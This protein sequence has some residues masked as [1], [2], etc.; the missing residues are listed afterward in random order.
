MAKRNAKTVSAL[1]G[2]TYLPPGSTVFEPRIDEVEIPIRTDG[3]CTHEDTICPECTEHWQLD[4][5]LCERL[6][7]ESAHP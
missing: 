6:P 3:T 1:A 2:F 7:W 4:H 5:L